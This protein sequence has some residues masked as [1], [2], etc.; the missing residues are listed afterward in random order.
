MAKVIFS[1]IAL[2]NLQAIYDFIARD[3]ELYADRAV[4]KIIRRISILEGQPNI[5]KVVREFGNP[6]I[7]ELIEG[8]YR[9]IYEIL[10]EEEVSVLRIYHGA[11][12]LDKL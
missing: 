4:G 2:E 6:V 9:V 12:L 1:E 11:R 3:S 10:S 8:R 7:R 5:G